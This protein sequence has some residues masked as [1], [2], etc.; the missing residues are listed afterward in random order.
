VKKIQQHPPAFQCIEM[1]QRRSRYYDDKNSTAP[2]SSRGNSVQVLPSLRGC[3]APPDY[4]L[5]I[6]F[7][8]AKYVEL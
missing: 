3:C 6:C 2:R 7:W 4:P 1:R 8:L 5:K